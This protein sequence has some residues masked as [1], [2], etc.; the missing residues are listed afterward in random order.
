MMGRDL[1]PQEELEMSVVKRARHGWLLAPA[2][3]CSLVVGCTDDDDGEE[4]NPPPADSGAQDSGAITP[5]SDGGLGMDGSVSI[6]GGQDAGPTQWRSD[7]APFA[8]QLVKAEVSA[9]GNDRFYGVT[10]DPAG[11]IY[12]V[13]STSDVLGS[14]A[15]SALVVAKYSA[16][17]VLD[18]TFGVGGYA[19]KNV[20]VGGLS[21]ELARGIVVQSSGKIVIVGDAEHQVF[22]AGIDGGVFVGDTDIVLVR[23]NSNGSIDTG[24]GTDGVVRYD[25]NVGA[26]VINQADGG[27]SL[28]GRDSAYSLAL[29]AA[30]KLVVHGGSRPSGQWSDG[31]VRTDSDFALLRLT[32]DGALDTT[33]G[34]GGIVLTDVGQASGSA[35]AATVLPDQSIIATGYT[36]A[37]T[38]GTSSQQPVL[39]KVTPTGAPDN[40]FATADA[41]P[42]PGVYYDYTR[43][44]MQRAEAYGAAP[45]GNKFVTVGYGPP[46]G[47]S[48]GATDWVFFRFNADGSKDPSFGIG[49]ASFIDVGG[50]ADNGRGLTILPDN[51]V[52]AI[53][54]GRLTPA[55]APVMG[56][57]AP[58]DAIVGIL[59]PDGQNDLSYGAGG[60]KAYDLG[61]PSDEFTAVTLSPNKKQVA[62][63]G[64]GTAADPATQDGDSALLLLN[65]P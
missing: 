13:G 12:A 14:T 19:I 36:T 31:G 22:G 60:Y 58:A 6:D 39:Y 25:L 23:F 55:T 40:T 56:T 45:Q 28:G 26:L 10:Y 5:V 50:H 2:L 8:E 43:P 42:N 48:T 34:T 65:I 29:A 64:Y 52:L 37:S 38:L 49:G 9:I 54:I 33:F 1:L 7:A 46:R 11:N 3:A 62:I 57:N 17:G 51:R 61:G 35:R 44:D 4:G 15:D 27:V 21:A 41:T 20:T 32:A 53:G 18:T 16:A 59:G 47:S 24:F 63:V 30:D